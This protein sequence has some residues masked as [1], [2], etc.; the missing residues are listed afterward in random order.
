MYLIQP[1]NSCFLCMITPLI[2][3][4][5]SSHCNWKLVELGGEG[6]IL[7]V[8]TKFLNYHICLDFNELDEIR[9]KL[10]YKGVNE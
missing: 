9:F 7:D 2:S 1:F 8:R 10:S 5:F 3:S 4:L 6:V